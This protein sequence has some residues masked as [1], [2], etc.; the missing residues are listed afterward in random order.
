MPKYSLITVN[1]AFQLGGGTES[2]ARFDTNTSQF[3]DDLT[4]VHGGHQFGFGANVDRAVAAG[5]AFRSLS[6]TIEDTLEWDRGRPQ[7]WPMLAGITPERE[8]PVLA[9]WRDR[10]SARRRR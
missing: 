8:R 5:L 2:E 6:E 10:H 4:L 3:S 9:A 1:N 7:G